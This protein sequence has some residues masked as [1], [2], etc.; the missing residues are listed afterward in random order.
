M[1]EREMYTG[2]CLE[3]LKERVNLKDQGVVGVWYW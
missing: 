2:F 3:N 1:R